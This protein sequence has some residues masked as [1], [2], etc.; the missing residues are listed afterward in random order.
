MANVKTCTACKKKH[1]NKKGHETC[2]SHIR[3]TGE[4]CLA[5]AITGM[6]VCYIHGGKSPLAQ[7][8]VEQTEA[9]N[10]GIRVM[11]EFGVAVNISPAEALLE[12]I[13]YTAG[14]VHFL[15][16]RLAALSTDPDDPRH[17]FIWGTIEEHDVQASQFPGTD[18]K[19]GS[20]INMWYQL[21]LQERKHLVAVAAAAARAGVEERAIRVEEQKGLLFAGV[22]RLIF[23]DLQLTAEQW[24]MTKTVV[25][26]R[27]REL[28]ANQ[29]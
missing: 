24:E 3:G 29:A 22:L 21:Y 20:G 26:S 19:D 8:K 11:K 18:S 28:E 2:S 23:N 12:E 6:R 14:H 10:E 25:P 9:M 16:A 17:P 27:M 15:R 5:Y 7:K 4:P 13:R 1:V